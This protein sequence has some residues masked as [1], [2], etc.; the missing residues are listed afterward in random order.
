MTQ[1]TAFTQR[2]CLRRLL[3]RVLRMSCNALGSSG[4]PPVKRVF[5]SHQRCDEGR[6][7]SCHTAKRLR[8]RAVVTFHALDQR[9]AFE[10]DENEDENGRF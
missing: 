10:D 5:G 8:S 1:R 4:E 9:T 7:V 6:K 3:I 2:F